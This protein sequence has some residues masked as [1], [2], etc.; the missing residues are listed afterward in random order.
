MSKRSYVGI[1]HEVQ[2]I[3]PKGYISNNADEVLARLNLDGRPRFVEEYR[4]NQVEFNSVASNDLSV[5]GED[6]VNGMNELEEA[7][8]ELDVYP[9]SASEYG[10]GVGM[11]RTERAS[12]PVYRRMIGDSRHEALNSISGIHAHFD[13]FPDSQ[14]PLLHQYWLLHALDPL[15]YGL[16]STSPIRWDG[17]NGKNSQRILIIRE[18]S[19]ADFSNSGP[20]LEYPRDVSELTERELQGYRHFLDAFVESG[21]NPA[22]FNLKPSHL[23]FASIKKRDDIGKSGTWEVR[24]FDTCPV[25]I[26][27]GAVALYKGVYDR[28]LREG[29]EIS[30]ANEDGAYH[31][32]QQHI[33]LPSYRTLKKM[34]VEATGPMGMSGP[35]VN[36]YAKHVLDYAEKGLQENEVKYLDVV[37]RM[38]L[39]GANPATNLMRRMRSNGYNERYFSPDHSA[40]AN[41]FMR[42]LHLKGLENLN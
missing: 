3:G 19:L 37:R 13:Q 18:Y 9:V 15:S 36:A 17:R 2:L 35:D 1:E 29:P 34:E 10:A 30:I 33:V 40:Q 5:V 16:T 42:K 14:F 22:D 39:V 27:L 4:R 31:Y 26:G 12:D 8:R 11:T 25:D 7:S 32:G 41:L 21:G 28:A 6:W 38:V 20:L 24:S 23:N